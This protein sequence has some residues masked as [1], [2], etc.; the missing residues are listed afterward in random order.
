MAFD[1]AWLIL[2]FIILAIVIIVIVIIIKNR[3]NTFNILLQ[4]PNYRI[5]YNDTYLGLVNIPGILPTDTPP[6][7][8][9]PFWVPVLSVG[10]TNTDPMAIWKIDPITSTSITLDSNQKL[11]KIL[12]T[13]VFLETPNV[14]T[15]DDPTSRGFVSFGPQRLVPRN[16]AAPVSTFGTAPTMVYTDLTNNRFNLRI[17]IAGKLLPVTVEPATNYILANPDITAEPSVFKLELI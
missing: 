10:V 2:G 1:Y 5:S 17:T 8:G 3:D 7:L 16:I 4:L 9:T 14:G 6:A 15:P 11:V 13:V 12:N